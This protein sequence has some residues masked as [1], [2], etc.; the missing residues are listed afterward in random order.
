MNIKDVLVYLACKYE[1]DWAKIYH[2]ISHKEQVNEEDVKETLGRLECNTL[3][4]L[5]EEYPEKLK[6]CY[7]PPFVLFYKGDISLLNEEIVSFVG[8]RD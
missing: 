4:L 2:A 7:N 3:V 5:E 8:S 6:Q 1:G